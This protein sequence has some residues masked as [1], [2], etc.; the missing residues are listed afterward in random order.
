MRLHEEETAKAPRAFSHIHAAVTDLV[1]TRIMAY[2]TPKKAWDKLREEYMG[3]TTTRNM[4]VLNLKRE[5][6]MQRM[7]ESEKVKDYVDKLMSVVNK[8]RLM[9]VELTDRRVVEK[10]LV[11]LSERFESKISSLEDSRD[12]TQITLTEL[13]HA[14]Q[15]QEQRRLLRQEDTSEGAMVANH[16]GK[17][18]QGQTR[19]YA[20][21]KK[22]KEKSSNQWEKSGGV[23]E[24]PACTHYKKKGHSKRRCWSKPGIQYRSCKQLGHIKRVCKNKGSQPTQQARVGEDQQQCQEAEQLFVAICYTAQT[25]NEAWLIDSGCTNDMATD[26]QS[27]INLDSSY[28]SRFKIG[29]GEFMESKE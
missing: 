20:G 22:G 25:S 18:A 16:K 13:V 11:S 14:L 29:N 23:K 21:D 10:V 15:A 12:M 26:L 28:C 2:E 6:E 7:H 19:R 27:F 9:G 5:F 4:Q 3:S 24:F 1:F 17:P 8:I